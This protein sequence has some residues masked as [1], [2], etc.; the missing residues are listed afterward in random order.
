VRETPA[1]TRKINNLANIGYRLKRQGTQLIKCVP[2]SKVLR[3]PHY[4]FDIKDS[5]RV[6]DPTGTEF[7]NDDAAIRYGEELA[8]KI[9]RHEPR[10][11]ERSVAVIDELGR[12][13]FSSLIRLER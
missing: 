1:T 5:K 13:I 6:V 10:P 7:P 9:A 4:F 3:M 8:A 11:I 2:S 12:E